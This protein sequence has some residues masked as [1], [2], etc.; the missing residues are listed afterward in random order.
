MKSCFVNTKNKEQLKIVE[1][2]IKEKKLENSFTVLL[3]GVG[4]KIK[5]IDSYEELSEV[6]GDF[7]L[8][9]GVP[10]WNHFAIEALSSLDINPAWVMASYELTQKE[11]SDIPISNL[12]VPIYGHIPLMKTK[13][14][15]KLTNG[16]CDKKGEFT[17]I[18]DRKNITFPVECDCKNCKNIIYNSVPLSLHNTIK[19][20]DIIGADAYYIG[21]TCEAAKLT[22]KI[23]EYYIDTLVY[24]K[25]IEFPIDNFTTGHF[26]KPVL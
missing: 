6:T 15:I 4:S 11:M 23:M 16:E 19:K 22:Q 9:N 10:V 21:F 24:K 8:G 17:E 2:I 25:N 1:N 18:T 14:C 13:N 12:L 26:K 7:I 5:L 20:H 3:N